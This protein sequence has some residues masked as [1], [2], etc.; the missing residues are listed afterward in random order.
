MRPGGNCDSPAEVQLAIAHDPRLVA[1]PV[2][3]LV[4]RALVV[5]LLAFGKTN[6]QFRASVLPVQ[7]QRDQRVTLPLDRSNEA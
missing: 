3:V 2:A 7:L 4:H 1:L 5:L 6:G